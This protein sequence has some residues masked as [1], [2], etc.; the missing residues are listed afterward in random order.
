MFTEGHRS[1]C[2]VY[3]FSDFLMCT[4]AGKLSMQLVHL[5]HL[6]AVSEISDKKEFGASCGIF[7]LC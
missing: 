4:T 3:L 1:E 2:R 5:R 7:G 6:V